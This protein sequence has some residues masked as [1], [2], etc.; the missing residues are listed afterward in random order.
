MDWKLVESAG[1]YAGL[2][3]IALIVFLFIIRQILKLGIFK[4][5]GSKGTLITINNII[6]KVF[7]VTV[8][9]LLA[10]LA[11][12]LFGKHDSPG[13]QSATVIPSQNVE[14][15][16]LLPDLLQPAAN[17]AGQALSDELKRRN[18]LTLNGSTLTIGAVGENRTVTIACNTLRLMNGAK[19]ITNGNHLFITALRVE[20]ADNA[21][22]HSFTAPN[23][24]A[25]TTGADGARGGDVHLNI[26]EG[27]SG[28][29]RVVLAGQDGADG[30]TGA[31]GS[32]GAGGNRGADAVKGL[33]DCRSGGQDGSAGGPGG[34]GATGGMGGKGGNGGDLF[35]D[36]DAALTHKGAIAFTAPGGKGGHSGGGGPGGPG[37]PGGQGGSGDGPCSGGHPGAGGPQGPAGDV[38]GQGDDGQPGQ[39]HPH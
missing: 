12:S 11:V 23:A 16:D 22:I 8:I 37:G 33:F 32:Q 2:A 28:A 7:W 14:L 35:L 9:A 4:S 30:T 20:F 31:Q 27:F 17:S 6:N 3:G 1:K 18:S 15:K 38:G 34:K 13:P 29:V 25:T 39:R 26:I 21:G 19:I 36:G 10:W 24:K 5:V